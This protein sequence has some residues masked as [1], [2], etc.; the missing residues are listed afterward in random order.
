MNPTTIRQAL[1]IAAGLG[2]LGL[3]AACGGGGAAT[4][5]GSPAANPGQ[6]TAS[7]STVAVQTINGSK[8]L[9][10]SS[11]AALY[12]NDQDTSGK[13]MCVTS[14][15]TKIWVPLTIS[16]GQKA[17]AGA[18]VSGT[19]ATVAM[20]GGKDQVTLNG[21]PLYTFALDG[22]PGQSHGNG[23]KDNFGGMQFSWHSAVPAGAAPPPAAPSAPAG[24]G[25]GYGGY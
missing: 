8:V 2:V 5:S 6:G 4:G 7:S 23:F 21:K 10:D 11:G 25:G 22:G 18:G 19:I 15:C 14:D 17:T 9:V 20:S 16:A 12:D 24:G 13:P 3:A 1:T